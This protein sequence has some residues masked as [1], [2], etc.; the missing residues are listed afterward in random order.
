M[1]SEGVTYWLHWLRL[2]VLWLNT[3]AASCTN[4]RLGC[5][6]KSILEL[7]TKLYKRICRA[8]Q[9]FH[10]EMKPSPLSIVQYFRLVVPLPPMVEA[11]LKDLTVDGGTTDEDTLLCID[12]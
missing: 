4:E 7:V 6:F 12:I 10:V 3:C 2:L 9:L 5:G 8:F 1:I 11:T